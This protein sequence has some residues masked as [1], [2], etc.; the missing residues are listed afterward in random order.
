MFGFDLVLPWLRFATVSV[1]DVSLSSHMLVPIVRL[2][3][4]GVYPSGLGFPKS[5]VLWLSSVSCF[6]GV[7]ASYDQ[8]I[9]SSFSTCG[10]IMLFSRIILP[11]CYCFPFLSYCF[12]RYYHFLSAFVIH[13]AFRYERL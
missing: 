2:F 9:S 12:R 4:L 8:S 11:H 1:V 13:D 3:W 5:L 6:S 10:S 7:S